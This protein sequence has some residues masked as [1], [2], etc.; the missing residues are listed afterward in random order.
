M[1]TVALDS[2]WPL[3]NTDGVTSGDT[4][5]TTRKL[6]ASLWLPAPNSQNPLS[7]RSGVI[8]HNWDSQGCTSLRPQ[9]RSGM[10]IDILAGPAV[11][12]RSGQ[13]P[14]Y[15]FSESTKS[16]TITDG[17][18]SN[19][20]YDSLYVWN[21]DQSVNGSTDSLHGP[22]VGVV[23]GVPNASPDIPSAVPD[24]ASIIGVVFVDTG[25]NASTKPLTTTNV[26]DLRS[27]TSLSGA[28]RHMLP[29]DSINDP[30]KID[31]ELRYRM[32]S[33]SLPALVDYWDAA[34]QKWRGTQGFTLTAPYPGTP[35]ANNRKSGTLSAARTR[36]IT[37]TV[38]D[39]GWPYRLGTNTYL[40]HTNG[41]D[42]NYFISVNS[43]PFSS[44]II[45]VS[46]VQ[47]V[48]LIPNS[49]VIFTGNSTVQL[50]ADILSNG[51]GAWLTDA[52]NVMTIRVDPA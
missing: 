30:G 36:I 23:E 9:L 27:S 22:V 15:V 28:V 10:D 44:Q 33:G 5:R 40:R 41:A 1:S 26:V 8:P 16:L 34:Q 52:R 51:P 48:V 24:G 11:V 46:D 7:V 18:A 45:T 4:D 38:P 42:M 14:Y 43:G 20:R 31:G 12:E 50:T 32:A 3:V 39:P 25:S 35:D 49:D 17:D 47:D 19:P 37:A 29:G 21:G 6:L 2:A 13:G